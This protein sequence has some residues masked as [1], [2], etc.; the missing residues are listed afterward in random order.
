MIVHCQ[1]SAYLGACWRHIGSITDPFGNATRLS[2]L[3]W[4]ELRTEIRK[5]SGRV[6][7]GTFPSTGALAVQAALKLCAGRPVGIFGFGNSSTL[8]NSCE[9]DDGRANGSPCDRYY[10]LG[11]GAGLL[12]L[13]DLLLYA[14]LTLP[15]HFV[16]II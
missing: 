16:P 8:G 7:V 10:A 2:P 5:A 13:H 14:S 1:P 3:A 6:T 4:L 11:P 9:Q 15:N 12:A